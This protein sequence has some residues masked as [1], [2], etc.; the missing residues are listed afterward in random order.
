MELKSQ[1]YLDL[2]QEHI[3]VNGETI[4]PKVGAVFLLEIH[5]DKNSEPVYYT[6][7]LKSNPGYL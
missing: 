4:V 3:K 6:L 7:N 5:F 1:A 2:M